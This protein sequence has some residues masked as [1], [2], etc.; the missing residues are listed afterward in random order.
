MAPR[1]HAG[2]GKT[3]HVHR[4]R[5]RDG[6]APFQYQGDIHALPEAPRR[7][8]HCIAAA[9]HHDGAAAGHGD[10]VGAGNIQH[11]LGDHGAHFC[12]GAIPGPSG[13]FADID[14]PDVAV[15]CVFLRRFQKQRR[16]L[17]TANQQRR[18]LRQPRSHFRK[19]PAAKL[20]AV[21]IRLQAGRLF[22]R[23]RVNWVGALAI[24][25]QHA[26]AGLAFFGGHRNPCPPARRD[27]ARHVF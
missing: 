13:F 6:G 19:L 14:E 26:E 7:L 4:A 9:D 23:F 16:F 27:Y 25:D 24:A 1:P 17:G 22:D 20:A 12:A 5:G 15:K 8:E 18:I 11:C 21:E 2:G 3:R 10:G